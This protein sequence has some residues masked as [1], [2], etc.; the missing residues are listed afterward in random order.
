[1]EEL[2]LVEFTKAYEDLVKQCQDELQLVQQKTGVQF[3]LSEL[4]ESVDSDS[5]INIVFVGQYSAGKS[6]II[7]C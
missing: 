3:D 5:M 1:M 7:K 6:S 2:K 4:Q